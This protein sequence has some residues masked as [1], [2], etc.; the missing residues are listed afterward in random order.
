MKLYKEADFTWT[1][2]YF[3]LGHVH[4]VFGFSVYENALD[5][6]DRYVRALDDLK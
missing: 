4:K 1:L 3:R 6:Y 2:E 5:F